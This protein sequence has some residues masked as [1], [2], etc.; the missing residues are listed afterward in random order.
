MVRIIADGAQ[1]QVHDSGI[2]L[3]EDEVH[4]FLATIGRS[5]K[6]GGAG[7]AGIVTG[8]DG[9]ADTLQ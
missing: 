4:R 2:G 8:P 1:V 3:T 6:R 5:S 7:A 9:F